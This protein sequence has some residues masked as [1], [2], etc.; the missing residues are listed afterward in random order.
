MV[1]PLLLNKDIGGWLGSPS[2]S[3]PSASAGLSLV[4]SLARP[5]Q[6]SSKSPIWTIPP[7]ET[8]IRRHKRHQMSW[9]TDGWG[10]ATPAIPNRKA[11]SSGRPW[12]CAGEHRVGGKK[13]ADVTTRLQAAASQGSFWRSQRNWDRGRDVDCTSVVILTYHPVSAFR[14]ALLIP[15]SYLVV[16]SPFFCPG[17]LPKISVAAYPSASL[18]PSTTSPRG[19][20]VPPQREPP[21]P[22]R[23]TVT[24]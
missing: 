20:Q 2:S 6:T 21:W 11:T 9:D 19:G 8:T 7:C 4:S 23:S 3:Q 17:R 22:T 5:N 13:S 15:R 14:L 18:S 12:P 24:A 10:L 16:T 1:R